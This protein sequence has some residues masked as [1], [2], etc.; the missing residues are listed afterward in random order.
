MYSI[1]KQEND[2]LKIKAENLH[3]NIEAYGSGI[4]LYATVSETVNDYMPVL[5]KTNNEQPSIVMDNNHAVMTN[6]N[7]KIELQPS[8]AGLVITFYNNKNEKL[9]KA[10]ISDFEFDYIEDNEYRLKAEFQVPEN[11]KLFGMGQYQNGK[12][13]LKNSVIPLYRE[14]KQ[15]IFPM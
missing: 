3:I 8:G 7:T 15:V 5:A 1:I 11:E 14:N 12:F 10:N 2:T 4:R 9:I 6:K 13:D